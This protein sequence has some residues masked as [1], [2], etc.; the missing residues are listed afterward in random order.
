MVW[1]VVGGLA[2]GGYLGGRGAERAADRT[3]SATQAGIN[4]ERR[5]FDITQENLAPYQEAG[6]G[7]LDILSTYGRSQVAPGDY[8]PGTTIPNFLYSG[9][10]IS[11][12][13]GTGNVPIF[14]VESDIP[15]LPGPGNQPIYTPIS[16]IPTFTTE[17]EVP[18]FDPANIDIYSDPSYN[19][20]VEETERAINRNAAGAG[21]LLSGNRFDA[22]QRNAANLAS[23]EY[24][25]IF[26]RALQ[27]YGVQRGAERDI[28][29]RDIDRFNIE[30]GRERDIYG[31][32]LQSYD[33]DRLREQ[34]QFDRSLQR[35]NLA[36]G[37]EADLYRRGVQGF[38]A[39]YRREGDIFRR[40]IQDFGLRRDSEENAFTRALNQYRIDAAREQGLRDRGLQDFNIQ[41]ALEADYLNRQSALAGVGQTA[42]NT[43]A[44]IG[45]NTSS[46]IANLYAQQGR[47]AAAAE[48]SRYNNLANVINQG[49]LLYGSG[50]FNAPSDPRLLNYNGPQGI[51]TNLWLSA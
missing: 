11:Y 31:R 49:A 36:R 12:T 5:Q 17:T 39:D 35:F 45:A 6:R 48:I 50:A 38:E 46:N 8:I 34:N 19:F 22:L 21:Q 47:N 44:A 20:I 14:N 30:R 16:N 10:P 13:G 41:R 51:P 15:Q 7:A 28:Y 18:I 33:I 2:L 42:I 4:E 27:T 37:A 43:G 1:G 29:D 9:Q 25:N 3:A 23:R 40:G 24:G 32:N 26:N